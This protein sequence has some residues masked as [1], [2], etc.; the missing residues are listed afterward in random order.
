MRSGPVRAFFLGSALALAGFLAP[1]APPAMAQSEAQA[2]LETEKLVLATATGRY[3][4]EV[5]IADEPQEQAVGLM[6]RESMPPR[7]GMLF[8]FGVSRMVTMWMRNTILSLDMIF[9]REDGTIARIAE[10]TTPYS[11]TVIPSGEPVRYVLELNA[12]MAR[13]IGL[14]PSDRAIGPRFGG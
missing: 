4:F 2:R 12:G 3:E 9:I 1:G 8:D 11:E 14:K 7:H 5:E 13:M 10:R 6:H